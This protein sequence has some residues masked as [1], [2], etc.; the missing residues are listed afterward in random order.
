MTQFHIA[1]GNRGLIQVFLSVQVHISD[2]D[3]GDFAGDYVVVVDD[4]D[5]DDDD[6]D[7]DVFH[8]HTLRKRL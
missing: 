1:S 6:F 8:H 4:D 5:D 3:D 2:S 7:K